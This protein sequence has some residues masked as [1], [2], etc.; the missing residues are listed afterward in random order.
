MM[1]TPVAFMNPTL[2]RAIAPEVSLPVQLLLL[3]VW[4]S[5]IQPEIVNCIWDKIWG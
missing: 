3:I 2:G 5:F 4:I 1:L